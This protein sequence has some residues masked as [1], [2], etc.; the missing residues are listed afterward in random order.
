MKEILR[1]LFV[2]VGLDYVD[3]KPI[4]VDFDDSRVIAVYGKRE[5][6][7]TNL[8][9]ILLDNLSKIR[10]TFRFIFL[11]MAESSYLIF[12]TSSNLN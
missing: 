9:K 5:F 11:M 6:G 7:K 1:V 4:G 10:S 2:E 3:F 12:I 8:L